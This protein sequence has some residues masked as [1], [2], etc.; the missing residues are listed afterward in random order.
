[1][2]FSEPFLNLPLMQMWTLESE[3]WKTGRVRRFEQ[4]EV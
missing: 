1:M 3:D 4:L 2:I